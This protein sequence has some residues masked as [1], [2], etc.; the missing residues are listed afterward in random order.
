MNTAA[1]SLGTEPLRKHLL[2]TEKSQ[3]DETIG[4]ISEAIPI[5]RRRMGE[6]GR[7]RVAEHFSVE[8]MVQKTEALYE[9]LLAEKGL[10]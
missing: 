1:G 2:S 10:A 3:I 7:K 5:L 6:A 8:Q 9:H 4:G